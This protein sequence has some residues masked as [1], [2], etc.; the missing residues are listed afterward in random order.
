[1]KFID[2]EKQDTIGKTNSSFKLLEEAKALIKNEESKLQQDALGLKDQINALETQI[3]KLDDELMEE[4]RKNRDLRKNVGEITG[5]NDET[6][7]AKA[8]RKA[9]RNE[10]DRLVN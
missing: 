6:A 2:Q 3:K 5:L 7:D 1:M 8:R 9:L 4:A 10:I